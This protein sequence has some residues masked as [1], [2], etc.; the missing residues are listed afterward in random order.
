MGLAAEIIDRWAPILVDIDLVTG[1]HGVF[2]VSCDEQLIFDKHSE[3]R[4]ARSGEVEARLE[5]IL[6]PRLNWK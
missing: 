1:D 2:K 4:H 3:G 6:G 5:P